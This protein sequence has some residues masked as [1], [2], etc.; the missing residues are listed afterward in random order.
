MTYSLFDVNVDCASQ[1]IEPGAYD[2]IICANVL[3]NAVNIEEAFARL[4]QL[5]RGG[6]VIVMVEPVIELYAALISIS[7][8]M[9]LVPFTDHRADSHKVFIDDA[10][11]DR[12]YEATGLR[13]LADYPSDGDPLRECGQ[14]L[15]VVG[16]PP[17]PPTQPALLVPLPLL[18]LLPPRSMRTTCSPICGPTCRATWFP[19]R[20][21]SWMSCR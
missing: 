2:V 7:I 4:D 3:H 18:S 14:R 12:V 16:D 20:C 8:K 5:R 17:T 6:G 21:G 10:E 11:W 19:H 9:S 13:R 1:D 15:I